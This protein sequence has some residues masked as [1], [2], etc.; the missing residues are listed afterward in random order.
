MKLDKW[1]YWLSLL[2]SAGLLVIP[3]VF[4]ICPVGAK[5]MRCYFAFQAEFLF[6]LLALVSAVSLFFTREAETKRISGFF[7][8]LLGIIIFVLSIQWGIGIC[9]HSNSP[10][11]L[12]A[13]LTRDLSILLAFIGGFIA[14][15]K[16]T[17]SDEESTK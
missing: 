14:F 8:L 16:T 3:L 6:A 17:S 2:V 1:T 4:P 9:G 12:T 15:R 11:Q 13:S 10:C 7:L 5:P